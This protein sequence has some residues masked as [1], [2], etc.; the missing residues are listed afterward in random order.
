MSSEK[1]DIKRHSFIVLN[2]QTDKVC[3]KSG[4]GQTRDEGNHYTPEDV[5]K[6][7]E[8]RRALMPDY[9][10]KLKEWLS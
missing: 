7:L 2:S 10:R 8:H 4:C 9:D 6:I 5:E 1:P 3:I